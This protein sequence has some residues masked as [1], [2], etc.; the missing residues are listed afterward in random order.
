MRIIGYCGLSWGLLY[1]G[2]LP[3]ESLCS[4]CLQQKQYKAKPTCR[5][6]V[7]SNNRP[8]TTTELYVR[9]YQK[10]RTRGLAFGS[11]QKTTE[12]CL[13]TESPDPKTKTAKT[14]MSTLLSQP[15]T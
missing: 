1:F 6:Q 12:F 11:A 5:N 3:H 13:K 2:K 14:N 9:D 10:K 8:W 4:P 7:L 15:E